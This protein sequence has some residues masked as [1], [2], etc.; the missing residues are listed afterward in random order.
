MQSNK[1]RLQVRSDHYFLVDWRQE[2]N[3]VAVVVKA[4]KLL[5]KVRLDTLV[6]IEAY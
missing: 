1:E 6:H 3:F 2:V 5:V 4:Y